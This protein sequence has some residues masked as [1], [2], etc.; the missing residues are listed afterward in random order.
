MGFCWVNKKFPFVDQ[1][2]RWRVDIP[3]KE[4]SV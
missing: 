1:K 2:E 3:G 4:K